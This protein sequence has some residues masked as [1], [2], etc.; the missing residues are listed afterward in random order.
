MFGD[1][2]VQHGR[3]GGQITDGI[4]STTLRAMIRCPLRRA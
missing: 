1:R 3:P 2:V 4:V